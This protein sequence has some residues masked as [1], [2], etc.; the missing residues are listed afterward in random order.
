MEFSIIYKDIQNL[1]S[2]FSTRELAYL[3]WLA[4]IICLIISS[5]KLRK[6]V[7]NVLRLLFNWKFNIIY[8]LTL[9]HFYGLI[10]V[11]S[12]FGFWDKSLL[13]DTIYWVLLS[14][15]MLMYRIATNKAPLNFL[16]N[17]IKDNVKLSV[18][19]SFVMNLATFNFWIEFIAIPIL[20]LLV[21][22]HTVAQYK[23]E[24]A[25]VRKILGILGQIASVLLLIYLVYFAIGHYSEYLNIQKLKEFTLPIILTILFIP[26]LAAL[27][28]Y[29][30]Y[31]D[32]AT[33]LKRKS[34]NK[35]QYYQWLFSALIFFNFNI[36]GVIRWRNNFV[37]LN[38]EE[39]LWSSMRKIRAKQ[40]E[41]NTPPK[42]PELEGWNPICIFRTILHHYS[43]PKYTSD[44]AAKC[45]TLV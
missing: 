25:P 38:L 5:A 32:I 8:L 42:H 15:S 10:Y 14:A 40:I 18:F 29:V 19:L 4:I 24:Y 33:L 34:K 2:I 6:S 7:W 9:G 26:F 17:A 30:Q 37:Y 31:E 11:L 45:T 12:I 27:N 36:K 3:S 44:S 21:G 22:M 41:E 1:I 20:V 23:K 13:K 35:L 16:K 39:S 28:L 43:T